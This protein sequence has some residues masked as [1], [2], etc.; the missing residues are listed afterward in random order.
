MS[1]QPG[2]KLGPYEIVE[3]VGR[4]GMGEVWKARDTRLNR[5]VAIKR[6]KGAHFRLTVFPALPL[7]RS[8][9]PHADTAHLMAQVN[10]VLESWIRDCPEQFVWQ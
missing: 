5:V 6:L 3:L 7:P 8:G 9:N 2:D 10:V 1:L 4:G